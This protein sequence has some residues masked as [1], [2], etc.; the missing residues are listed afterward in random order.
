MENR[1]GKGISIMG[2]DCINRFNHVVVPIYELD[3]RGHVKPNTLF[4][5]PFD[6]LHSRC[7][8]YPFAASQLGDAKKILDV[9]TVKSDLAWISWLESLP[10]EVHATDYDKPFTPFKKVKFHRGDLR[11]LPIDSEV[12][13][14]ILAVSVIEHVGLSDSQVLSENKPP[15]DPD[16]DVKAFKEMLRMVKKNGSIVM[17]F[18]FGC[19]NEIILGSSRNYTA[20]TIEKFNNLAEPLVIDYYEY[21]HRM[22]KALFSQE[23]KVEN[24]IMRLKDIF[25]CSNIDER[26]P[27][28]E[29]ELLPELPGQVTWRRVPLE[30]ARAT[31]KIHIDGVLCGVWR[32]S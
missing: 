25:K 14:K 20:S 22:N 8:E 3:E 30:E 21:Q 29:V 32:K 24:R 12:F 28:L 15:I 19:H 18:P 2:S 27:E 1:D 16:G 9:G 6:Y 4:H 10:I 26:P 31:N 5:R 23:S 17:T 13:D 7:V 11:S